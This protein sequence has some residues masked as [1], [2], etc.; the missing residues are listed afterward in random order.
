MTSPVARLNE[1]NGSALNFK[2]DQLAI[3]NPFKYC[4]FSLD[5]FIEANFSR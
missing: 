4:D 5:K 2:M 3:S 1:S